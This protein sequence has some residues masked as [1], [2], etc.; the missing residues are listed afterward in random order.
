MQ[1]SPG[2]D[3][4]GKLEQMANGDPLGIIQLPMGITSIIANY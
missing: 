1:H 4:Y 3:V 2:L